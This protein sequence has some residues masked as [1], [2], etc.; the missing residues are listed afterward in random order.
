M[1]RDEAG[2]GAH[3]S[4][5]RK[6]TRTAGPLADTSHSWRP[7]HSSGNPARAPR[8]PSR[9]RPRPARRAPAAERAPSWPREIGDNLA[10]V[11]GAGSNPVTPTIFDQFRAC[12][13]VI[14]N[15]P[16]S[17]FAPFMSG[18]RHRAPRSAADTSPHPT[19]PSGTTRSVQQS[20]LGAAHRFTNPAPVVTDATG[21]LSC[22]A[23]L[24]DRT[25]G[26]Q[27]D[28]TDRE[29]DRNARLDLRKE[30][31]TVKPNFDART[32]ADHGPL[33]YRNPC[34]TTPPRAIAVAREESTHE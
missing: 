24:P 9:P 4:A 23:G 34:G 12:S 8:R 5:T 2:G 11:E 3:L 32:A 17:V 20:S 29:R 21:A 10:A 7:P 28:T 6:D 26:E 1:V 25:K 27:P 22:T 18:P 14:R 13:R 33:P 30:G 31:L 19:A 16:F 15:L